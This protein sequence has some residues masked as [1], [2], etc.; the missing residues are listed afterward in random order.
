MSVEEKIERDKKKYGHIRN[1]DARPRA[2]ISSVYHSYLK[3]A[4]LHG[5]ELDF[6]LEDF[7]HCLYSI[8]YSELYARWRGSGVQPE[9]IP[10]IRLKKKQV[11]RITLDNIFLTTPYEIWRD[12]KQ[13]LKRCTICDTKK[14]LDSFTKS[15]YKLFKL[16]PSCK[17]CKLEYDRT[18]EGLLTIIYGSQRSSSKRR[19]HPM[20]DYTKQELLLWMHENGLEA[21][22]KDWVASGYRK[23]LR[24]STD[25]I[26]SLKPYILDNL[27]LVTW[28]ENKRRAEEDQK[29]GVGSN[30]KLCKTVFQYT[31]EG[32]FVAEHHSASEAARATGLCQ[33][34]ISTVA[35]GI[36]KTAGGF[37]WEKLRNG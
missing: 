23:S 37:I 9:H 34:S 7:I 25:R 26:D 21:L 19:K 3:S 18:I 32:D 14:S 17:E 36:G 5:Y 12:H 29:N 11:E 22:Y 2:K 6:T 15:K 10:S 28:E 8:G 31:L 35:N 30:G 1:H 24:P 16:E 27:E 13:G 4:K 20:P 33:S